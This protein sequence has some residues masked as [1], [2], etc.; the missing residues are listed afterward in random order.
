[1]DSNRR[2]DGRLLSRVGKVPGV[3][4]LFWTDPESVARSH[5]ED[6]EKSDL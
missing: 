3:D 1:M 2:A 5:R 4:Q 6:E